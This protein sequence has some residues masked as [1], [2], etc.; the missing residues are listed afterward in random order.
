VPILDGAPPCYRAKA[1]VEVVRADL[2]R[3]SRIIK[4]E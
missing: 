3:A 1:F 4:L 2:E